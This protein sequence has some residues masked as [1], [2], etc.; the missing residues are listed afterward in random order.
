MDAVEIQCPHCAEA[1]SVSL[2]QTDGREQDLVYDCEICCRPIVIHA[3]WNDGWRV[4]AR[5]ESDAE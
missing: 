2:D 5:A 3:V 4:T 1:F